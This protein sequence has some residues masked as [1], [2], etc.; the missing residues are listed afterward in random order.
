MIRRGEENTCLVGRQA[1]RRWS[2][3][4]HEL[5]LFW[6]AQLTINSKEFINATHVWLGTRDKK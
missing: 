6:F 4:I 1:G 5:V 2:E 3:F